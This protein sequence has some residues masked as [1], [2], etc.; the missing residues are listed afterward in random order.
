MGGSALP[1]PTPETKEVT[2]E[3]T[4]K[5]KDNLKE[6]KLE[7]DVENLEVEEKGMESRTRRGCHHTPPYIR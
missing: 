7:V 2:A 6:D 1:L 5:N 3:N 4:L